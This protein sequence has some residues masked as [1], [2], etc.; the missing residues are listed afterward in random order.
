MR[1]FLSD[2]HGH[3]VAE[4][5]EPMLRFLSEFHGE[6]AITVSKPLARDRFAEISAFG[7]QIGSIGLRGV[8]YG[9]SGLQVRI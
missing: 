2:F 7:P 1:R 5:N 9:A 6:R 4:P 3:L 8:E